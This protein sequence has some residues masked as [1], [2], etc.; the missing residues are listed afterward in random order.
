MQKLRPFPGRRPL[1]VEVLPSRG[2][3]GVGDF[4]P[5]YGWWDFLSGLGDTAWALI[6]GDPN[7]TY[8]INHG[9]IS[10]QQLKELQAANAADLTRGMTDPNTGQV[11]DSQFLTSQ[12]NKANSQ[13]AAQVAAVQGQSTG[14]TLADISNTFQGTGPSAANLIAN[15]LGGGGNV[16]TPATDWTKVLNTIADL[17]I[18]GGV[19]V[20]AYFAWRFVS[21]L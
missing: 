20:G 14:S 9:T 13:M 21:D 1:S 3:R 8:A 2:V 15:A 10:P 17:L 11:T 4:L 18:I 5:N 7:L 19:A 16:Q 12:I 6:S